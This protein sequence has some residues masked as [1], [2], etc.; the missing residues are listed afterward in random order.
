MEVGS[1]SAEAPWPEPAPGS[2]DLLQKTGIRTPLSRLWP[3]DEA[4]WKRKGVR[5]AACVRSILL[6]STVRSAARAPSQ[7]QACRTRRFAFWARFRKGSALLAGDGSFAGQ[8]L[9][10]FADAP[11][12]ALTIDSR[13]I[14]NRVLGSDY[15]VGTA[16]DLQMRGVGSNRGHGE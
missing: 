6:G 5:L 13:R 12:A 7:G 8:G 4:G 3:Q 1:M 9:R 10:Q 11:A 2:R 14:A 15:L 16:T